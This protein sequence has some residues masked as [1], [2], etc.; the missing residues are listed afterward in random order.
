MKSEVLDQ[1]LGILGIRG[2]HSQVR[3]ARV[4][5]E[6]HS[7]RT[8]HDPELQRKVC[9]YL[10]YSWY[11]SGSFLN[12]L[13]DLAGLPPKLERDLSLALNHRLIESVP[14]LRDGSV[15][16]AAA[17]AM[18][19]QFRR[20]VYMPGEFIIQE[21]ELGSKLYVLYRGRVRVE[22][23]GRHVGEI[24]DGACFGEIALLSR[25]QVTR[26]ASC[27]ADDYCDVLSL[28]RRNFYS[29]CRRF[30]GIL[31]ALNKMQGKG[32]SKD[33]GDRKV[34]Q[35]RSFKNR[36]K[37]LKLSFLDKK[38]RKAKLQPGRTQSQRAIS[39]TQ[40]RPSQARAATRAVTVVT[41][42]GSAARQTTAACSQ[43]AF[44]TALAQAREGV[45][46]APAARPATEL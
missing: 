23:G 7:P 8:M 15:P 44:E 38:K 28:S 9:A 16:P 4:A 31:E 14:M 42:L 18:I 12:S 6:T 20:R 41:T 10:S 30:P 43:N 36:K 45:D 24:P 3:P 32:D 21:G 29:V 37:L 35:R 2:T 39:N 25:Q 34:L 26:T 13:Q 27:I 33:E 46:S 22:C 1:S 5:E 19:A 11:E 17:T 40:R